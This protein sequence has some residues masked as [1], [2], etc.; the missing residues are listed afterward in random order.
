[1]S[2][3]TDPRIKNFDMGTK[4]WFGA[5]KRMVKEKPMIKHC[6]DLWYSK[7][8]NDAN[9]VDDKGAKAIVLELGSGSSYLKELMPE[10]ITSDVDEGIADQ[11]IDARE[12]PFPDNS[13]KAIFAT[14]VFHHIPDIE[15][16]LAEADRVLIP[17]GVISMVDCTH[18]PLARAFFSR[19]HPEPY[20]DKTDSWTFPQTNSML[21]SNQALTWI[22]FHRDKAKFS[23]LFPNFS[24]T[25][26][27]Y[28]PWFS[29]LLSG[30]VNL[31]SLVPGF[32]AP[33]FKVLDFLLKP[34]D[35]LCAIHWHITIRKDK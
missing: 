2:F 17:G 15:K 34:L 29:Y 33:V 5:Q 19:V 11:V 22:I 26:P 12:L 18:T 32:L 27:V 9:S 25:K 10:V 3:I 31:R 6:Y 8:I 28:L 30:G 23:E 4:E 13:V 21:D 14:H 35:P 16:F 1:M 24:V 7:L 20:N